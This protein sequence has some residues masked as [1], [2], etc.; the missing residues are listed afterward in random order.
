MGPG[1]GCNT[2]AARRGERDERRQ[3]G[4]GRHPGPHRPD[5][6]ATRGPARKDGGAH[7]GVGDLGRAAPRRRRAR[8]PAA[9]R[10]IQRQ[11]GH[12]G[13]HGL[14]QCRRCPQRAIRQCATLGPGNRAGHGRRRTHPAPARQ[15]GAVRC[16]SCPALHCGGRARDSRH[17]GRDSRCLPAHS[18]E[19][20]R[21]RARR[22]APERRSPRPH[23][24]SRG[25]AGHCHR[26]GV[27]ARPGAAGFGRS[28]GL[29]RVAG[30][31]AG[32]GVGPDGGR[33]VGG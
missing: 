4:R 6:A 29:A 10:S 30:P 8:P 16:R 19:L 23:H 9:A 31:V 28:P 33:T 22:L 32:G 14:D 2:G 3:R 13:W 17:G 12:A 18:E 24:R 15:A 21:L 7:R 25:N 11:V 20:I 26:S 27:A 1:A 5:R